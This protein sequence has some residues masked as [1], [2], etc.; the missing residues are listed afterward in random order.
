MGY[1][2]IR[3]CHQFVSKSQITRAISH[4][5]RVSGIKDPINLIIHTSQFLIRRI[6]LATFHKFKVSMPLFITKAC[7]LCVS[8]SFNLYLAIILGINDCV[9]HLFSSSSL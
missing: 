9:H 6:H 8:P 5:L 3:K 2:T 7:G 4:M 1:I